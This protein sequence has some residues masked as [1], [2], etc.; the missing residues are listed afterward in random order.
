MM[1]ETILLRLVLA[2]A[3]ALLL[4]G[5]VSAWTSPNAVKR[6]AGIAAAIC[7]ALLAAAALGAAS[8]LLVAGAAVGVA[9]LALGAVLTVRLQ[10]T[11]GAIEAPELDQAD[12]QDE[13]A[14]RPR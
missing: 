10:E 12:S 6:L 7:G 4:C 8:A 1:A 13:E 11:Y 2:A 5:A 9:M 14:E 3:C